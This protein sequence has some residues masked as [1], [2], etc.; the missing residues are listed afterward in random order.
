[1]QGSEACIQPETFSVGVVSMTL[2]APFLSLTAGS[3]VPRDG[4]TIH[5][6]SKAN[7]CE[8]KDGLSQRYWRA[9]IGVACPYVSSWDS[10]AK[11]GSDRICPEI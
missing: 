11:I 5:W 2:T 3:L 7:R 10:N 8:V 4:R 9:T 6:R 1:M